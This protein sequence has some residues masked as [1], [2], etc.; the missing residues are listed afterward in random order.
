MLSMISPYSFWAMVSFFIKTSTKA[1]VTPTSDGKK[2]KNVCRLHDFCFVFIVFSNFH[3][4]FGRCIVSVVQIV[5]P[6]SYFVFLFCF[7]LCNSRRLVF[8][9]VQEN[10]RSIVEKKD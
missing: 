5:L 1:E 6:S 10:K 9:Q 8:L 4:H 3:N 7:K 2:Q